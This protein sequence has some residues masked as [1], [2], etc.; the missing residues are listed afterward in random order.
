MAVINSYNALVQ[1]IQDT[2]EDDSTEFVA[3]IPD[4]VDIAEERL[5]RELE[6][7]DLETTTFNTSLAQGVYLVPK[8]V[9]Y[10]F[11]HY[12]KIT[13]SGKTRLLKKRRDDF[14]QDYWPD[15]SVQD[16]PKYYSDSSSGYF[17][18]V[19]TPDSNYS[20]ILKYSAQPAKLTNSNQTNYY[21]I[22]CQDLLYYATMIEMVKFM[23]AWKEVE[24]WEGVYGKAVADWNIN[25]IRKRRDD[26]E[27]PQ[28]P[29]GGPNTLSNTQKSKS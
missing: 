7:Q 20:Y 12:F 6:L 25:A 22:N 19:P 8:P 18:V 5:F 2:A 11:A 13:V 15:L 9:G 10:K 26:G 24:V 4:A 3:F 21:T 28:N 1:A 23:K 29:D 17:I 27:T 16:V 14:V